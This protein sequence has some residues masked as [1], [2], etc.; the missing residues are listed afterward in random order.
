MTL[1][2]ERY[3]AVMMAD[4]LLREIAYDRAATPRIPQAVRDRAKSILRHYPT[5]Y[6]ME[7]CCEGQQVFAKQLDPLYKMIKRHEMAE[8]IEED[9][10]AQVKDRIL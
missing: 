10:T 6:D 9:L 5:E 3:R 7:R 1:P 4:R 2:D 8:S